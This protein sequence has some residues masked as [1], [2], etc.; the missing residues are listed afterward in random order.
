MIRYVK[1]ILNLEALNPN[2][3]YVGEGGVMSNGVIFHMFSAT[4][5]NASKVF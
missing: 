5:Q 1:M 2:F 4:Q 3:P